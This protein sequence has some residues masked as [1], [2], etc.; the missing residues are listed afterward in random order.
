MLSKTSRPD[1]KETR[2]AAPTA[3]ADPRSAGRPAPAVPDV[4]QAGTT[5]RGALVAATAGLL[6]TAAACDLGG[7]KPKDPSRAGG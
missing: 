4:A 3:L 2:K 7:S 5:R 6:A 1:A